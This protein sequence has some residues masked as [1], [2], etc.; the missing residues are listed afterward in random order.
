MLN[1]LPT[2]P[3]RIYSV[4]GTWKGFPN[5][6]K[7]FRLTLATVEK[8]SNQLKNAQEEIEK[9]HAHISEMSNDKSIKKF[10]NQLDK[11]REEKLQLSETCKSLESANE[12]LNIR[13]ISL[14]NVIKIQ[15][16][17]IS[18]D[19]IAF[20]GEKTASLLNKWRDKVYAL[21]V[22]LKSQQIMENEDFRNLEKKVLSF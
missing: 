9:L 11:L 19:G 17:E 7:L 2:A 20:A 21:L 6:N 8:Q 16:A 13:L 4:P 1:L 12:L 3:L 14:N 10:E 22:Q 18:K 5:P 15:E